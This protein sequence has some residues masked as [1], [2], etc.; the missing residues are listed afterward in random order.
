MLPAG[1]IRSVDQEDEK[2]YVNRTKDQIKDAPEFDDS[3]TVD[4]GYRGR[5]GSYY[6]T[7]GAGYRDWDD[8]L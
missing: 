4:E 7:G 3:L 6:G 2:V 1:V 5:L 8:S